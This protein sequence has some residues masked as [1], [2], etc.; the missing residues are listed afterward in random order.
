MIPNIK[1]IKKFKLKITVFA[2]TIFILLIHFL[3]YFCCF[4]A[5]KRILNFNLSLFFSFEFYKTL[6]M[7]L[8]LIPYHH[9]TFKGNKNTIM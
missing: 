3:Q 1:C 5:R 2:F 7:I 4:K 9:K 6:N 8:C